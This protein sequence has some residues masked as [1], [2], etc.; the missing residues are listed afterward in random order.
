MRLVEAVS[1]GRALGVRSN[2]SQEGLGQARLTQP[3]WL[4]GVTM[5]SPTVS[6]PEISMT[7]PRSPGA[8]GKVEPYSSNPS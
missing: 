3:F 2:A 8:A 4:S 6:A 7:H 5:R 1:K